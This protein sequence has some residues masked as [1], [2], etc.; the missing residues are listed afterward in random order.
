MGIQNVLER[1][2]HAHFEWG[3][4][5]VAVCNRRQLPFRQEPKNAVDIEPSRAMLPSAFVI[6]SVSSAFD[7][8]IGAGSDDLR[9]C[10]AISLS[11]LAMVA[12]AALLAV[13]TWEVRI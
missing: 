13:E 3:D 5:I 11:S 7:V 10:A 1:Y 2:N 6:E 9:S 12:G 4:N 8:P